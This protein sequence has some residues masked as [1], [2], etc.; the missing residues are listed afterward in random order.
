[1]L[2][3]CFADH[4]L[5]KF[6]SIAIRSALVAALVA[7]TLTLPTRK[8]EATPSF[9]QQTGKSCNFCHAGVPRLNDTGLGFKNNGFRLPEGEKA[10]P[11]DQ[12][13]APAQ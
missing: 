10:P 6:K 7:L 1:M 3:H 8:A 2:A 9:A 5:R 12:K 4:G 13:D 11:K